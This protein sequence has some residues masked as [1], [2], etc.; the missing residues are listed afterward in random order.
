MVANR[1]SE[2]EDWKI[3]LLEAGEDPNFISEIP[4]F[5]FSLQDTKADWNYKSEKSDTACLGTKEQVCMF[6]RGKV[7]GG[8]STINAMLYVR[9]NPEDYNE[10]ESLGNE[11]WGYENV[12]EYFKKSENIHED[13]KLVNDTNYE[14]H[15][16]K[17]RKAFKDN[18]EKV[19]ELSNMIPGQYHSQ[20]GHLDVNHYAYDFVNS[21]LKKT[22]CDAVEELGFP[23]VSDING[24][25]QLGFTNA[26]G[27]VTEG[28]RESTAKAFLKPIKTRPNLFVVKKAYVQKL[29][30]EGNKVVGVEFLRNNETKIVK[31]SKEVVVSGGAINSPQLLMLS[32]IGPKEHLQEHGIDVVLD[33]PGVGGNLQDH[34]VFFGAPISIEKGTSEPI[35]NLQKMDA[36]YEFLT[37][38]TGLF[39]NVGMT[40]IIGFVNTTD[41]GEI[42]D[43]QF[44]N[45]LSPVSDTY[46]FN[47]VLRS[48]G[49]KREIHDQYV[50]FIRE[51][52]VL[53]IAP[54]LL[55]PKSIGKIELRSSD[56][57]DPPKIIHNFLTER[58]DVETLIRG[59]RFANK[60]TEAKSFK[61]YKPEWLRIQIPECDDFEFQSDS[62]WECQLRQLG[63]SLYHPVGTCKMGPESDPSAV[64]D[65]RLKVHGIGNLR[66]ADASIMPVITR[67]NT[68]APAIMI[69]EKVSDMIKEDWSKA[70]P[71][72][73]EL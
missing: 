35:T 13:F 21:G 17:L 41:Q 53:V 5:L 58:E 67:G 6:P 60:I 46:F 63:S 31:A 50:N 38:G 24:R 18:E 49:V 3:L 45:M 57:T 54:T 20:G 16:K 27:T 43:I 30:I 66:V 48:L 7:L 9:V 33:K 37:R 22:Y 10:W 61:P 15:L 2:I 11:G 42:P 34:V 62:Y 14:K 47:E 65:N 52:K 8:C 29:H 55:R 51:S 4:A 69:G 68:N 39:A 40:D 44:H 28:E 23:C 25:S 71:S 32:G 1:L 64:V 19:Y 73:T 56:P 70:T 12:L 59:I 26:M 72:H 36:M